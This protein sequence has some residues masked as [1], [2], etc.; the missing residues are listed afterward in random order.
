MR[1]WKDRYE[2]SAMT[3]GTQGVGTGTQVTQL[4]ITHGYSNSCTVR[5]SLSSL[6]LAASYRRRV[7]GLA[8]EHIAYNWCTSAS[9]HVGIASLDRW[10]SDQHEPQPRTS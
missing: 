3:D 4:P 8:R 9:S 10:T 2:N 1:R 7:P 6:A 5:A